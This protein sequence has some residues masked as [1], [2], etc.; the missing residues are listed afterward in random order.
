MCGIPLKILYKKSPHLLIFTLL[1]SFQDD[2]PDDTVALELTKI[3][4]RTLVLLFLRDLL[5]T[6]QKTM[7]DVVWRKMVDRRKILMV[8]K[9]RKEV[10]L[11]EGIVPLLNVIV[12]MLINLLGNTLFFTAL[13]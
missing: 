7:V 12:M 4:R 13:L 10:Y 8:D 5:H 2:F 6:G 9:N 1:T 11:A 3:L